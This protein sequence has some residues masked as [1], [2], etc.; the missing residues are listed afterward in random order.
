MAKKR[1]VKTGRD[2]A[3]RTP[4]AGTGTVETAAGVLAILVSLAA[5]GVTVWRAFYGAD[6]IDESFYAVVSYRFA[7]GARPFIDQTDPHQLA[8]LLMAPFVKL[9]L[10]AFGDTTG[11]LL[12]LRMAWLAMNAGASALWFVLLSRTIP[13]RLALLASAT[14]FSF[15][16]YMIPAPSFNTLPVL[17]G[18]AALALVGL[19]LGAEPPARRWLFVGSGALF[20]LAAFTYPTIAIAAVLALAGVAWLTRSWKEPALVAAGGFG[21]ASVGALALMP[22][23]SGVPQVLALSNALAPVYGWGG[24]GASSGKAWYLIGNAGTLATM[25]YS[26]YVAAAVGIATMVFRKV[27]WWL[28][29]TLAVSLPLAQ[30]PIIEAL[31]VRTLLVATS[32]LMAAFLSIFPTREPLSTLDTNDRFL[33]FACVYALVSGAVFAFTSSQGDVFLGLGAVSAMPAVLSLLYTALA[34]GLAT[35][36]KPTLAPLATIAAAAVLTL[37]MASYNATGTYR[38]L[39]P[40]YLTTRVKT[41]PHAGLI[42]TSGNAA[43]TESLWATMR[44]ASGPQ[45]RVLSYQ[46]FP[47]GYLYTSATPSLPF[48]WQQPYDA[49]GAPSVVTDD[50]RLL[51][52]PAHRPTVII[53][54]LGLPGEMVFVTQN[55]SRYDPKADRVEAFVQENYRVSARGPLWEVLVPK[56]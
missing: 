30:P 51:A 12:S 4:G 3:A 14:T 48:L 36:P 19:G 20:G 38:D 26:L 25:H 16:P 6:F 32:V 13:R 54:N 28:L 41:G 46:G 50:L 11:I 21:V 52:D 49:M 37:T 1:K 22:F 17:F 43:A 15:I 24:A 27:P 34:N 2:S 40:A 18:S 5:V 35:A 42:T 39:P 55:P 9:H 23:V 31:D 10:L 7:M 47:A 8:S 44:T 29:V 53:R 45:D 56:K 33:R